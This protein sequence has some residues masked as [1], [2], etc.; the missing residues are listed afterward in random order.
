ML[1]GGRARRFDP[2]RRDAG[3]DGAVRR[4]RPHL[5]AAVLAAALERQP[6]VRLDG[7]QRAAKVVVDPIAALGVGLV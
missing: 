4:F 7:A 3:H 5:Q 2:T 1:G 6:L